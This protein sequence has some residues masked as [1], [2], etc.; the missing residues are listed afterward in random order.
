MFCSSSLGRNGPLLDSFSF[1]FCLYVGVPDCLQLP[2]EGFKSLES[3]G[4]CN[5]H[6]L[7]QFGGNGLPFSRSCYPGESQWFS[8]DLWHFA[9]FHFLQTEKPSKC[10]TENNELH[11]LPT[12]VDINIIMNW[13]YFGVW[14]VKSVCVCHLWW[15]KGGQRDNLSNLVWIW[16]ERER[17]RPTANLVWILKR[18]RESRQFVNFGVKNQQTSARKTWVAYSILTWH[19]SKYKVHKHQ[20][21]IL[22]RMCVTAGGVYVPCIE[23]VTLVE[24]M[25]L[26]LR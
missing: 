8:R 6:S 24:F 5:S 13:Q 20:R 4:A 21:Y 23:V 12:S 14:T 3:F 15:I 1:L 10:L 17:E 9:S 26:V 18:E 7:W 19:A 11:N 16:R 2:Q 25:D 22:S